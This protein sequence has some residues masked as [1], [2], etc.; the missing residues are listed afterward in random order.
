MC[1]ILE[2]KEV[3]VSTLTPEELKGELGLELRLGLG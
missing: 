2:E 1:W 3:D